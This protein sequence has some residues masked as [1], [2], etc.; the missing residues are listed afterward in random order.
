MLRLRKKNNLYLNFESKF[1]ERKPIKTVGYIISNTKYMQQQ[2]HS[3]RHS[4]QNCASK[5]LSKGSL[6]ANNK[7]YPKCV[8][9]YPF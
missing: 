5:L 6:F 2:L 4:M 1:L 3:L 7:S 9:V 8:S